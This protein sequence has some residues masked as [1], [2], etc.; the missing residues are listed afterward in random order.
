MINYMDNN[1]FLEP[2]SFVD[3]DHDRVIK[4][5][6]EFVGDGTDVLSKVL[7]LYYAVREE[8][9]Y[10]PDLVDVL[11]KPYGSVPPT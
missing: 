8:I 1:E 3:S 9:R 4:F 2:G 11:K 6:K 7:N 10:D 5:A